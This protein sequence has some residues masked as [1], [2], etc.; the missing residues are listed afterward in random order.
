MIEI[1]VRL[2]PFSHRVGEVCMI[3]GTSVQVQAFPT[4]LFFLDLVTGKRWE[5]KLSWKGP[6]EGFTVELDLIK[7]SVNIFGQTREGFCRHSI[8]GQTTSRKYEILSLGKH[9]KLD[10]DLVL[11]RMNMEEVVPVLFL[12]GQQVPF[13]EAISP[14]LELLQ[15][16]DKRDIAKQLK[17]FFRVGFSGM[18]VPRLVDADF[19][20]IIE[21]GKIEGSPLALLSYGYRAMRALFFQE[22]Q[23]TLTF[24]PHLPPEFHAGRLIH[25]HTTEGDEISLEWSKKILKRVVIKP[26]ITRAIF[27]AL[28]KPLSSFR[29]NRKIRQ[30]TKLPLQL[31]AGKTLVLDRFEK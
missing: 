23:D 12:L 22:K 21:E 2:K 4:R 5:E 15:F 6:V 7:G 18:C 31:E 10:W 11:R 1:A 3:P 16:S 28:Q 17:N 30:S 24:L 8:A 25:L 26:A 29:I 19:Q 13:A 20:G 14:T 27:L 9:T